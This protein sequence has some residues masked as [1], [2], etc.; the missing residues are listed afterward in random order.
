MISKTL[1]IEGKK[2]FRPE[3][4]YEA[5]KEFNHSYEGTRLSSKRCILSI[6]LSCRIDRSLPTV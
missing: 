2:L 6:R 5:L 4:D 1:G 3:D